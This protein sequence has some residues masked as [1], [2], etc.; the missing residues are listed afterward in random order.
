MPGDTTS[1]FTL[2]GF[3]RNEAIRIVIGGLGTPHALKW[4]TWHRVCRVAVV[5]GSAM[6]E[7]AAGSPVTRRQRRARTG[8]G[9]RRPFEATQPS[10]WLL[11]A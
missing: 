5:S 10:S 6:T 9:E 2:D 7:L 8:L 11:P 3:V 1:Q 4:H